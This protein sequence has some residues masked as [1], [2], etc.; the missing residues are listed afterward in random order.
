M[1][2]RTFLPTLENLR[3]NGEIYDIPKWFDDIMGK[4]GA[5]KELINLLKRVSPIPNP[6]SP[7]PNPH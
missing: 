7:I 5:Y 3:I 1:N 4:D 2:N 6:Q